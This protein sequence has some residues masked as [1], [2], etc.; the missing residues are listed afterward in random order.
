MASIIH[1][2]KQ[3]Q[4]LIDIAFD[5]GYYDQPHLI[6]ISNSLGL[7]PANFFKSAPFGKSMI[8]YND[9]I[10]TVLNFVETKFRK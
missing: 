6:K 3:K 2:R 1:Q 4:S 5:A 9:Y 8:F 7:T 10:S